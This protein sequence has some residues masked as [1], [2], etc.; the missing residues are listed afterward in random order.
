ME[1]F[2][3]RT[4]RF[5]ARVIAE[6]AATRAPLLSLRGAEPVDAVAAACLERLIA[7]LGPAGA[8]GVRARRGL[9]YNVRRVGA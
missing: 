8:M 6:A 1:V 4:R 2:I 9:G 7:G 3:Q 5:K